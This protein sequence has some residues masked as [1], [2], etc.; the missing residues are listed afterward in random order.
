MS[1]KKRFGLGISYVSLAVAG[2]LASTAVQAG[3]AVISTARTTPAATSRADGSAPGNLTLA[4]EGSIKVGSGPAVTIDSNN[5]FTNNGTVEVTAE[6]RALGV[7]VNTTGGITGNLVD[8]GTITL[9]GPAQS[10]ALWPEYVMG[11]GIEVSGTGAFN[12]SIT[13]GANSTLAVGGNGSTGIAILSTMNGSLLNDGAIKLTRQDT[14]GIKAT[15]AISGNISNGGR[16][17]VTGQDAIGIYTGGGVGGSLIH[18]GSINTGAVATT[19]GSTA[20]PAVRGGRAIWVAGNVNGIYLEGNGVRKELEPTTQLADGTPGDSEISVRGAGEGL[21]VGQGGPS[22]NQNIAV[23]RLAGN[24]TGASI[25]ARGNIAVETATKATAPVRAVNITGTQVGSTIYRTTLDGGFRNEGDITSNSRD[26]TGQGIRIGDYATVPTLFNS[27]LILGRGVDSGENADT[28]N[29]GSGGGDAYGIIIEA[30]GSLPEIINTGKIQGDSRGVVFSG[31]GII[32]YSGTLTSLQNDGQIIA[33][34]KGTGAAVALDVSRNTTGVTVRNSGSFAGNMLFGTGADTLSSTG[35]VLLGNV[36][37]G[38]GNDNVSL[39]NTTLTGNLDLG[40]GAHNVTLTNTT[41]EGGMLLGTG[42]ANLQVSGSTLTIPTTSGVSFTNGG[43][44]GGSTIN[45]NIDA[46]N[47]TVG[48]LK[49][50]GNLIVDSG[51]TLKTTITGAVVDQFTV[52]LIEAQ[53]LT[54]GADLAGL[55]PGSTVMYKRE[56]RLADANPNILQYRI[57]RRTATE[58]GLAPLLGSIYDSSVAGLGQDTEFAGVMA[59]Y[60]ERS[61]FE[62][63]LAEMVPDTSDAARRVALTSRRLS[64]GAIQRRMGGFL[65]N[66]ADPLGR[67]RSG[68]WLQNVTSFGSGDAQ[69]ATPG[70]DVFSLGFTAGVD[71]IMGDESI[72]GMSI[73]QTFGNAQE[74]NRGTEAVKLSTTSLDFYGR[75]NFD[76]A[77]VQGTL[78]YSFNSYS[79]G[80]TVAF[81]TI[82]RQTNGK[83]PGYQWS[84]VVDVGTATNVGN[85]VLTAYLRGAYHNIFRHSYEENGGGPAIDLRYDSRT[86]TSIR[87]GAGASAE[88]RVQFNTANTLALV[89]RV[90]YAHEFNRD[91]TTVRALFVAGNILSGT[92]VPFVLQ[93][94]T[95]AANIMSGGVGAAWERR[96]SMLSLDYDAEKA[97]GYLGHTISLTYRQRF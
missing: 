23:G 14:Y 36:S 69:G 55:Q 26:F 6:N 18:R 4:P 70:Y 60:T 93:G 20:V 78:G 41:L 50:A 64:Q 51:T 88:H 48:S 97:G 54:L 73:S 28:G 11:T 77:Y 82:E 37:M 52:N 80:R 19:E 62:A 32:D 81:D 12:G 24:A 33:S 44:T 85:T 47:E 34:R 75:S 76:F 83:S 42:T 15:G 92:G 38:A 9:P 5:S 8:N 66:K 40:D 79:D 86:F 74:K 3:D 49:A 68:F 94:A 65:T 21:F 10:S 35:G 13:R 2:S 1:V 95:P 96:L 25:I 87:G 84:G 71:A 29:S 58:L 57:T 22:G 43:I 59:A 90:D 67:F 91:P 89:A 72:V 17:D 56:I 31:Y 63:A 27:G 39:A 45:F 46:L 53:S 16:I 30:N 7:L 61:K